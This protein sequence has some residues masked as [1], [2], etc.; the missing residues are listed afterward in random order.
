MK[1]IRFLAVALVVVM[2]MT[3][4]VSAITEVP[5]A[6]AS[7]PVVQSVVV[8]DADGV[9]VAGST[10]LLDAKFNA[11]PEIDFAEVEGFEDKWAEVAGNDV[12]NAVVLEQ[13]DMSYP[14]IPASGAIDV[15]LTLDSL[16]L[17]A[18]DALVILQKVAG[19]WKIADYAIDG[20]NVVISATAL[21]TFAAV[22]DFGGKTFDIVVKSVVFVDNEGVGVAGP[23][24]LVKASYLEDEEIDLAALEID[25]EVFCII[26]VATRVPAG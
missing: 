24:N 7:G 16:N 12:S 8:Y 11:Q 14:N 20:D 13:I 15:V 26:D 3:L 9:G 10:S 25:G 1:S 4:A 2:A 5:S 23:V 22:I 19:S 6:E 21:G 17:T 18:D